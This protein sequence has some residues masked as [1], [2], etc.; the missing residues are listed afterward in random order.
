MTAA[1]PGDT[2]R[3]LAGRYEEIVRV[4]RPLHLEGE[5]AVLDGSGQRELVV[6]TADDVTVSGFEFRRS[7]RDMLRDTAALR[8]VR[9]RGCRIEKNVFVDNFFAVYLEEASDC[10]IRDNEIRGTPRGEAG[11]ANGIH[12]WNSSRLRIEQNRISGHR[13]GIYLEFV[14][15]SEIVGNEVDANLRYGLHFM[16]AD[17]NGFRHNRFSAN[18]AG[19]AVMYS[20]EAEME[21]NEFRDHE[22]RAS[23]GLLLKEISRSRLRGNQFLH[24]SIGIHFDESNRNFVTCNRF[25]GNGLAVSLWASAEGN[26]FLGNTFEGNLFDFHTNSTGRTTNRLEGN[27]YSAYLGYD[28]DRDGFGEPPHRPFAYSAVLVAR[29]PLAG[30]L[31][32]SPFF[33]LLDFAER[34]LPSFA[35]T[36]LVDERP[37][38]RPPECQD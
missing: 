38:L 35:P 9:S 31:V 23:Y 33:E 25:E 4:D 6:V 10:G 36:G 24:N 16:Y 17:R 30:L 29:F 37:A 22:G 12:A 34:L 19:V 27:Y 1:Q 2:V 26:E 14:T 21:E 18:G 28:R 3:V 32:K 7:G 8:V 20:R 13:D 11:S 5:G 15:E